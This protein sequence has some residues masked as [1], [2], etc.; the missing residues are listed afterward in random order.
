MLDVNFN[1]EVIIFSPEAHPFDRQC[2]HW[3][4][5]SIN[6]LSRDSRLV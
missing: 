3:S 5:D 6:A 4:K 1:E 2:N